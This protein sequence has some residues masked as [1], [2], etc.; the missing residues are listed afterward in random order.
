MTSMT[1]RLRL[2]GTCLH[3]RGEIVLPEP[4]RE[5]SFVLNRGLKVTEVLCDGERGLCEAEGV[6]EP[7]FRAASR[8]WQVRRER[9]FQRV[10][11]AYEGQ[12]GPWWLCAVDE[13]LIALNWYAVWFPQEMPFEV[14]EDRAEVEGCE[15]Y[16][17]LK[18][19]WDAQTGLW[20]YG[21]EGYD[22]FNLLLYRRACVHIAQGEHLRVY[23]LDESQRD[24]AEKSVAVFEDI[25]D[26]YTH[27]L[28]RTEWSG[29]VEM[30]CNAPVVQDGG[31]YKRRGLIVTN[32]PGDD[33]GDLICVNGHELGHEWCSG[34]DVQSWEDWLNETGAEWAM[35]LYALSRGKRELAQRQLN[36]HREMAKNA[37]AMRP[38]DGSRPPAGV[39]HVGTVLM[40][41][42]YEAFG[43][44]TVAE[45]LRCMVALKEKTTANL[46]HAMREA[47]LKAAADMLAGGLEKAGAGSQPMD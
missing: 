5:L 23:Y 26:F 16:L 1:L 12:V 13:R 44:E 11:L 15:D 37:P 42:V 33:D 22:P 43:A 21:G 7:M 46:L 14:Q 2:E 3:V 31:A 47:G 4:L 36:A 19:S 34:A 32:R 41:D 38:A 27:E 10:T 17:L 30:A 25:L 20:R 28:F 40:G 8:R 6:C 29:V 45:T 9:P 35:L 18:G 24:S 39:H